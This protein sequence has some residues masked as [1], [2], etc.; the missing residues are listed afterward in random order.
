MKGSAVRIRAS[1]L[2]LAGILGDSAVCSGN[3]ANMSRTLHEHIRLLNDGV[4]AT[5][6][7]Y[8]GRF[9]SNTANLHT[10]RSEE[11]ATRYVDALTAAPTGRRGTLARRPRSKCFAR[12]APA[13]TPELRPAEG[14]PTGRAS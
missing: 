8:L 11:A 9:G 7:N 5:Y 10:L 3:D 12:F 4:N 2:G 1:A 13:G 6:V 14:T